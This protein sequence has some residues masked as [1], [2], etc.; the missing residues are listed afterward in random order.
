M[1]FVR[2][3]PVEYNGKCVVR[4]Y[5]KGRRFISRELTASKFRDI[6]ETLNLQKKPS[7][8]VNPT[9]LIFYQYPLKPLIAINLEDGLFYSTIGTVKFFGWKTV[10]HQASILL[11][12]LMKHGYANPYL[13]RK[14][15]RLEKTKN[16]SRGKTYVT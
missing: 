14:R 12:I 2:V 11:R 7:I 1:D 13:R 3:E 5:K 9:R 6:L 10:R 4:Y 15:I 16:N 8:I